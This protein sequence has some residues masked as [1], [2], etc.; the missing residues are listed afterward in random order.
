MITLPAC[1]SACMW[2]Y[3]TVT[4]CV[5]ADLVCFAWMYLCVIMVVSHACVCWLFFFWWGWGGWG[6]HTQNTEVGNILM[7]RAKQEIGNTFKSLAL[8]T[9]F[10]SQTKSP[11]KP[12]IACD[13]VHHGIVLYPL[14]A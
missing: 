10:R 2:L 6:L 12:G 3:L 11:H 5:F 4:V 13:S 9:V 1:V 7:S 14:R 8:R